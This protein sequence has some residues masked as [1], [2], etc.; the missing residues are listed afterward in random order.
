MFK[1]SCVY[2]HPPLEE[3][4]KIL[5]G[6]TNLFMRIGIKSVSMDDIARDIG[7]SKKTIYKHYSDKKD[8][9]LKV[10]EADHQQ[11][12]QE[13][14][15]CCDTGKNAVQKMI[16]ISRYISN[17]HKDINP[18][19]IYDLQKYYP[20]AWNRVQLYQ[21]EFIQCFIGQNIEEGKNE[22]LYRSDL[23]IYTTAFMYGT[24]IRGM[25][26][27]LAFKEN[28]YNFKTLHLQMVSYHLYGICTTA[29]RTYL[30]QH[31]N[32]ITKEE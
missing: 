24:L 19:V 15:R 31:I 16:D 10:I 14:A 22:V 30:K 18:T 26:E 21:T 4:T 12:M 29:G 23:D 5:A 2:L 13:C 25:M 27:Q 9:V 7:V 20:E 3:S 28:T 17:Q 11:E 6:A 1:V 32:E 8:L